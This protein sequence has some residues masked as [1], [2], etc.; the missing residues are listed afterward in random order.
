MYKIQK[1]KTIIL[2]SAS[3]RRREILEK[4]GLR[5]KVDAS[6]YEEDLGLD[7]TPRTL[8]RYLSQEKARAI[9]WKYKN[10]I[11]IA[12][13]TFIVFKK[14][15]FGKPHTAK[16]ARR[17][18]KI[19]NGQRHSV[20]TGFTILNTGL[21]TG[22]QRRL[23]RSVE[24]KVY[25]KR[26]TMKEIGAYVKTGEPLDKAGGYAIQGVG[27]MIVKKIEGDYYNVMGLPLNAL[28]EG[29][30]RFGVYLK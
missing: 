21:N 30:K 16:E 28:M 4:T 26:M 5:F 7:L 6:D 25:F 10:A 15:I 2:A 8:A 27:A 18:L 13:D 11:I 14:E 9:A 20:I 22:D 3:P 29:L 24:T 12:A 19:L 1:G 23:S 17:M